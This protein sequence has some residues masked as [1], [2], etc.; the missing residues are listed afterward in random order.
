MFEEFKHAFQRP[1]H[2]H[3][4]LI[5]INVLLFLILAVVLVV[6]TIAGFE[7]SFSIIYAQFSLPPSLA[8]FL[9]RPWTIL[10]YGFT[11]S[12]TDIWHIIFNMI[13]LYWF[14]K[15]FIEYLGNDRLIALYVL[16]AIAGGIVYL[17]LYNSVPFFM[18]RANSAGMVGAS[19]A[20]FAIMVGCATLL[21][22]YTFYLMFFG[23]VRIKYIALIFIVVS[24]I[25]TVSANAG[26]NL[27]HLGGAAIGYL[28]VRQLQ[29]G[30][31]LGNWITWILDKIKSIRFRRV[32]MKINRGQTTSGNNSFPGQAV[33]QKEIDTI[34]DKIS[35]GGYDSL[36]REEKEKLFRAGK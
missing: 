6:T 30:R 12:L 20:I 26:G 3:V 7:K 9:N 24:F 18:Q 4:Q 36:S 34:L 10:T 11:H 13:S 21:P 16:G 28:Y 15:L 35:A 17:S 5:L 19:G 2:A 23:P 8:V 14:G 25:G 33:S 27:A 31:N 1:N 22:N 29:S 32:K